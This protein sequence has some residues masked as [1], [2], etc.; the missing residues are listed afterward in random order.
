MKKKYIQ[1]LIN[2]IQ[3]KLPTE[4]KNHS[5]SVAQTSLA[6][7]QHWQVNNDYA[8][9]AGLLH[10][11]AKNTTLKDYLKLNLPLSNQLK[12]IYN[13]YPKIWHALVGPY[14]AQHFFGLQNKTILNAIKWHTTGKAKMNKLE[15][16][17]FL[18]DYC[19]KHRSFS[20]RSYIESL[21]YTNL[22]QATLALTIYSIQNLITRKI[23]IH[24]YTL[25][26][27]NYYL[28]TVPTTVYQKILLDLQNLSSSK[29]TNK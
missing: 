14:F 29:L 4:K 19:E 26:C 20:N 1:T 15:Q 22:D 18:A 27:F 2:Q 17:I 8:Y 11:I 7:A 21:A 9:L 13:I 16:I 28:K 25:Q 6:L 12:S 10:D 3:N 24:P 5:L 23:P